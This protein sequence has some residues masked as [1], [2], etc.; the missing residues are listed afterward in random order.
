M[1]FTQGNL[2]EAYST[3][4]IIMLHTEDN[5]IKKEF[6]ACAFGYGDYLVVKNDL[7]KAV[8]VLKDALNAYPDDYNI[9]SKLGRCYL[10]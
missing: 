2:E 6:L 1:L 4:K 3:Y 8:E 9:L 5:L 7:K 10:R